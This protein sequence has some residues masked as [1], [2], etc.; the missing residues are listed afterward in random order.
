M[1]SVARYLCVVSLMMV[2]G[3]ALSADALAQ[4][5]QF[6]SATQTAEGEFTQAVV[7]GGTSVRRPQQTTGRFAFSRPG[8]FRWEYELPYPQLLVGDGERLWTW[9]RDLNQVTVRRIGDAL[10]ATPAAILFGHADFERNFTLAEAGHADGL[11]WVEA[12]PNSHSP[13]LDGNAAGGGQEV[14]AGFELIRFGFDG[15]RLRR[16]EVRDNFGQTTSIVLTRLDAN[17]NLDAALFRFDPPA[18]ADII[19]EQ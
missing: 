3:N 5:R 17:P 16:M 12:R 4:L 15:E 18:G 2:T 7:S 9:D 6:V 10:G 14:S 8:K 1:K 19:G 13:S 11:D